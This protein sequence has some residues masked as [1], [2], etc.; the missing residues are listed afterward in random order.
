[1]GRRGST[2]CRSCCGPGASQTATARP[3]RSATGRQLGVEPT[4]GAAD[5]LRSLAT[6][7]IGPGL[8]QL[9]V[10]AVQVPQGALRPPGQALPQSRPQ[11]T[12][13]PATPARVDRTP[14]S[15]A[16]RHIAPGATGAQH[17]PNRRYHDPVSFG[18]ST[19]QS[20]HLRVFARAR[21]IFLAAATAT[22]AT[23]IDRML[24]CP[25]LRLTA[26]STVP[27]GF[28]TRPRGSWY[29]AFTESQSR[30]RA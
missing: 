23:C 8:M 17:L 15:I 18:R 20:C 3:C 4:L 21:L 24:A 29:Q 9:D 12:G 19:A 22:Q 1:V 30:T 13:A 2:A 6:R 14:R 5:R 25:R 7:R 26:Q 28:N 27:H 11:A 16:L 10:R